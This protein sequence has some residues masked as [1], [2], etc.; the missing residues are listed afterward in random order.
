MSGT[1]PTARGG[2]PNAPSAA[3]PSPLHGAELETNLE[4]RLDALESHPG[5]DA[6]RDTLERARA[7]REAGQTA[8][9]DAQLT[10]LERNIRLAEFTSEE[11]GLERAFGDEEALL[12]RTVEYVPGERAPVRLDGTAP[13]ANDRIGQILL[14]HVEQ[15]VARFEDE[16]LTGPQLA[17]L[18]KLESGGE[19]SA[20]YD[21]YRGSRIDE[22]AKQSVLQDP[23]LA[24]IYVTVQMERGA[25]FLDA[26]TGQWYDMTTTRAWKDHVKKYG[27]VPGA[28][29][30]PTERAQ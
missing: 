6:M 21:A 8:A 1:H 30:L 26:R 27:S 17:A 5:A 20:L 11:G 10:Q 14:E 23:R 2:V 25:D 12:S 7:L 15:A 3:G 13:P 19:R 16:G 18:A 24:D 22:F 9:A 4:S 29:R 28:W